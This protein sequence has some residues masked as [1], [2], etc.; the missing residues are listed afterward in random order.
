MVSP[1]R[2]NQGTHG[3]GTPG[4]YLPPYSLDLNR[5]ELVFSKLKWFTRSAAERTVEGLWNL[6]GRL[7]ICNSAQT[8]G[9]NGSGHRS[10]RQFLP[11][12][13][14]ARVLEMIGITDHIGKDRPGN[15]TVGIVETGI[16]REG[17][18]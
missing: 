4:A 17:V 5:I 10:Q 14:T 8:A 1:V 13:I 12:T 11:T 3:G 6:L 16:G 7:P 18:A 15:F 2:P 9:S